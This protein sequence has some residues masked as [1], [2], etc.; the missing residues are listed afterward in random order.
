MTASNGCDSTVTT[1]ITLSAGPSVSLTPAGPLTI[2]NGL[3]TTLSSSVTN[4]NYTYAWSDANGV[5]SGATGTT[6][7]VSSAGTYSLGITT[8]AGCSSTSNSVVV[9][10]IS[11]STPSGLSTSAI[12]LDRATMNWSSVTNADHYDVRILAQGSG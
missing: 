3:S 7:S 6:Y 4:P 1:V 2:C 9:S 5:I 10:V 12:Q 11:V 8:P